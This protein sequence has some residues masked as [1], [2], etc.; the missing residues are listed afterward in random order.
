VMTAAWAGRM[1]PEFPT[2]SQR[3]L[4]SSVFRIEPDDYQ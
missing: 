1:R 2:R 4:G 3:K